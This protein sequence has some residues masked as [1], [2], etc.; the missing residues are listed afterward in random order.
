MDL[1]YADLGPGDGT[2]ASHPQVWLTA[3]APKDIVA[4]LEANGLIIVDDRTVVT[5]QSQFAARAGPGVVFPRHG[6]CDGDGDRG[7]ALLVSAVLERA[8]TTTG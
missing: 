3:D 8:T 7:R 5:R 2:G 4:Q 6:R 1:E